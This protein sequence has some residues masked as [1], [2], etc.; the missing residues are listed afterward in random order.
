MSLFDLERAAGFMQWLGV[1]FSIGQ[2]CVGY[3]IHDRTAAQA[4]FSRR[5]GSPRR[6]MVTCC[7]QSRAAFKFWASFFPSWDRSCPIIQGFSPTA[8]HQCLGRVDASTDWGC[9]GFIR[10]CED[11]DCLVGDMRRWSDEDRA[12][13]FVSERESTGVMEGLAVV[14]WLSI[15]GDFC[16]GKRVL[17]ETDNASVVFAL[18][19]CY[20]KRP[21]MMAL[22]VDVMSL[23]CSTTL[24]AYA[25]CVW[26][27]V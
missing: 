24:S 8:S 10:V 13:A 16:Y 3:I 11:A 12:L 26:S 25:A 4:V 21:V 9:G 6:I 19:C 20:S 15:F 22:I 1:G 23:C 7:A 27:G 14:W 18:D 5:G 2:A 17:L